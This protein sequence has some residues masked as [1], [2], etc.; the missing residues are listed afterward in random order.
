[1]TVRVLLFG[2]AA[3]AVRLDSVGV[4]LG[5]R[6][7]CIELARAIGEQWPDLRLYVSRGRLA[8]NSTFVDEST[9]IRESDEVALIS[10]VSGG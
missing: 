9:I 7:T 5:P 3:M 4:E 6:H 10:M 1:M 8:V 2:P